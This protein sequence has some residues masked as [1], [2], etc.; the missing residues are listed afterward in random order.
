VE[1]VQKNGIHQTQLQQIV[2]QQLLL[3]V[4]EQDYVTNLHD[5]DQIKVVKVVL[6][7]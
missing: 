7:K 6:L 4:E 2:I 1:V 3:V 5:L